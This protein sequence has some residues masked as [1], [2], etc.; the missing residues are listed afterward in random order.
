MNTEDLLSLGAIIATM[1]AG[2]TFL[3]HRLGKLEA[4]ITGVCKTQEAEAA[5]RQRIWEKIDDIA[6]RVIRLEEGWIHCVK[7]KEVEGGG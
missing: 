7:R 4:M 5:D 6:E 3:W 2:V 1:V